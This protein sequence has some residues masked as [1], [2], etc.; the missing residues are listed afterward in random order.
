MTLDQITTWTSIATSLLTSIAWINATRRASH[1]EASLRIWRGVAL[2]AVA[3]LAIATMMK[4]KSDS[5]GGQP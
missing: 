5:E 1:A 4:K 2:A 3:A